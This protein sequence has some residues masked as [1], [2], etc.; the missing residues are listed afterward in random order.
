[1][2]IKKHL[3]FSNLRKI[4]SE[5]IGQI[6]DHRNLGDRVP[7]GWY[8]LH[9]CLMSGFA[10]MYFQD[11]SLLQFQRRLEDEYEQN[12]LRTLFNVQAIPKGLS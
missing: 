9:D 4:L 1:M 2:H 10:M 7:Y 6:P 5:R 11:P 8:L 12:N 3:S